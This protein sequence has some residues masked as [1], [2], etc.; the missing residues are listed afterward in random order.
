MRAVVVKPGEGHRVGNVEFLARSAD[1]PR[2][3]LAVIAIQPHSGGPPKHA[4]AAEDDAFYILEG[5]LTFGVDGDEVVAGPGT[6]VLVPPGVEHTFAATAAFAEQH[7]GWPRLRIGVN[8]GEAVMSE[9]GGD[10]HVAYALVGDTVNTGSRLEALARPAA[11]SS[12]PR[13]ARS[14]PP[15]RW[16]RRGPG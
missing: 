2:F 6:F 7:P 8:S 12:A 13:P 1:T 14:C 15:A 10:G 9:I 4:H 16:S 5:E 3:N 11:C